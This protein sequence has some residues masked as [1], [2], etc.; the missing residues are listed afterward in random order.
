MKKSILIPAFAIAALCVSA[1]TD[2]TP[3]VPG[4]TQEGAA[5]FLPL[6][7]LKVCVTVREETYTPGEFCRYAE[8][9]LKLTGLSDQPEC[10]RTISDVKVIP[11]GT[12]DQTQIY[13]VRLNEKSTASFIHLTDEGI[14]AAINAEIPRITENEDVTTKKIQKVNPQDYLTEE[15]LMAGSTAKMA[16]LTAQEIFSI[17]ESRN[18]ITRGQADYIP[19]DGESLKLIMDNLDKQEKALMELFTGV[20]ETTERAFSFEYVPEGDVKDKVLFR[21]SNKVGVVDSLNLAGAP[22]YISV[23][24]LN[25]LQKQPEALTSQ[26]KTSKKDNSIQYRIPGRASVKVYDNRQ[27]YFNQEMSIAQFGNIETLSSSLLGK[28]TNM[29][30]IFDTSTGNISEI[31]SK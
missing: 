30:V 7:K 5:Y 23:T 6:T 16:E 13:S 24:N 9:Y 11:A 28:S 3:Y 12:P 31:T 20:S 25:L 4:V 29:S 8:R 18:A 17:R 26:K 10:L 22:V 1:Q 21:I 19:K 15:I 2:V 27:T 14:I